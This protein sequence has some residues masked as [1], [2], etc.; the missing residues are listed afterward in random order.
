MK[1]SNLSDIDRSRT[2]HRVRWGSVV[3][4][5]FTGTLAGA[6]GNEQNVIGLQRHV[7]S[8]RLHDLRNVYRN[9]AGAIS[10]FPDDLGMVQAS[11]RVR[12]F[13]GRHTVL[14]RWGCPF[15][16]SRQARQQATGGSAHYTY[17][18]KE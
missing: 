10:A 11:G 12:P 2:L 9:L 6:A 15:S 13:R 4:L 18:K 7:R 14:P 5:R 16:S 8:F 17:K 1:E 3:V